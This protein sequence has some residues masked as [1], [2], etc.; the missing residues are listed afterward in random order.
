MSGAETPP[1][2][3]AAEALAQQYER[4][5]PALFDLGKALG[6]GMELDSLLRVVA[7]TACELLEVPSCSV[8]LLDNDTEQLVSR[9]AFG[10]SA[11]EEAHITF[12]VGEGVAGW[13]AANTETARIDDVSLDPRFVV[14]PSQELTICSMLCVPITWRGRG[15]GVISSTSEKTAAFAS[16]DQQ[17][18]EFLGATIAGD[19]ETARL[20]R[21]S[22]TDPLTGAFNRRFLDDWLPRQVQ[23]STLGSGRLAAAMVDVDHFKAV[24]DTHGHPVGDEV[25][26]LL[27]ER[28]RRCIREGDR[29][30]RYGGEEF[31]VAL[32][33]TDLDHARDIAERMR[34]TIGDTSFGIGKLKLDLKVSLGV[35]DLAPGENGWRLIARADAALL[36]AK[37]SGR[38]QVA[39]ASASP[40]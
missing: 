26:K 23:Q 19:L 29:L 1:R 16:I 21:L 13:V 4:L 25:L 35:A 28:L 30:I 5:L 6:Q 3:K 37:E 15:I 11:E 9:G 39:S 7:R 14:H 34:K 20:Y 27:A 18:L 38:N 33:D 24:N 10:L 12:E 31:L 8:M 32:V 22:M 36:Q 17:L 40:C 2:K